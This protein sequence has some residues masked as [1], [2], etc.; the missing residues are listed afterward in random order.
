MSSN[1]IEDVPPHWSAGVVFLLVGTIAGF[2][3]GRL[4]A[5]TT[6]IGKIKSHKQD[7]KIVEVIEDSD[8]QDDGELKDFND[9]N[10]EYKLVLVV[11]TDLGMTKGNNGIPDRN[12]EHTL[13]N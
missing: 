9:L 10:E 1:L 3:V 11:R 13:Q 12:A 6:I 7:K 2:F 4:T 5:P 8:S